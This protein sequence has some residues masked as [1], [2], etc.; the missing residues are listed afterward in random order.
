MRGITGTVSNL[1]LSPLGVWHT[2]PF[3]GVSALYLRYLARLIGAQ[4]AKEWSMGPN[5]WPRGPHPAGSLCG[6]VTP[7]PTQD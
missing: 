5:A 4:M 6:R 2:H 7:Q 3:P 1:P